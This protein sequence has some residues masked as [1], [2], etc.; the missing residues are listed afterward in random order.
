MCCEKKCTSF[1]FVHILHVQQSKYRDLYTQM[2]VAAFTLVTLGRCMCSPVKLTLTQT[3]SRA[4]LGNCP[5]ESLLPHCCPLWV[6]WC[7]EG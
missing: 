3:I 2:G 4:F 7:F 5:L 1:D 6:D